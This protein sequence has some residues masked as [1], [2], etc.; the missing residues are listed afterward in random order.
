MSEAPTDPVA[1]TSFG[2]GQQRV[3]RML[4]GM[5]AAVIV[6]AGG[7][8]LLFAPGFAVIAAGV[9]YVVGLPVGW[10]LIRGTDR[11]G[12][13]VRAGRFAV[14]GAV[15][16]VATVTVFWWPYESLF[17][18]AVLF[19]VQVAVPAGAAGGAVFAWAGP[20]TPDRWVPVLAVAGVLV[21]AASAVTA[22][23]EPQPPAPYD[24]LLLAPTPE[25]TDAF[26]DVEG[27]A[28]TVAAGFD[29]ATASGRDPLAHQTW[30]RVHEQVL[31][32]DLG[33]HQ[34]RGRFE[35]SPVTSPSGRP[36]RLVTVGI[37]QRRAC[38]IVTARTTAVRSDT[39]DLDAVP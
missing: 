12:T 1:P 7:L 26:G 4:A 13:R 30:V 16:A 36:V 5:G 9:A 29:Q 20:R 27:L 15:L 28:R 17:P 6:V 25:V 11:A 18:M 32:R 3:G 38:V 37:G 33:N 34:G 31:D 21:A 23:R 8:W 14:A 10:W 24:F 39:C 19:S 2:H 35:L 22:W